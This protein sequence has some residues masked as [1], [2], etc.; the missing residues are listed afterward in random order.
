MRLREALDLCTVSRYDEWVRVP[1]S[2]PATSMLA[3]MF[4]PGASEPRTRPLVGHTIAVYE[5]DPRL[6]LVWPVDEDDD[7]IGS[8]RRRGLPE[9]LETDT[10]TWKSAE[11]GWAVVLLHG[12][13]VWQALTWYLD[14]GSGVGG[15]V[16]NFTPVFAPHEPGVPTPL[17]RWAVDEWSV[18][19]NALINVFSASGEWQAFDP[20]R[21]ITAAPDTLHPVDAAR[22]ST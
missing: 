2:R 12:A 13:P 15:Y 17:E 10:H 9:W 22:S 5:P 21:R 1:G 16:P 20:V 7:R 3:G 19:L 4:D 14:W 18:G 6:S 11:P 8:V